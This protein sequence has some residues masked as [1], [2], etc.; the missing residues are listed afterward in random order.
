M[1]VRLAA[2]E[3]ETRWIFRF[4]NVR[5][6]RPSWSLDRDIR[7]MDLLRC[8]RRAL[9]TADDFERCVA[10]VSGQGCNCDMTI[11][12]QWEAEHHDVS[13]VD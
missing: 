11:M 6:Q 9:G 8:P 13:K 5:S 4:S 7:V 1:L 2:A 12:T 10:C 3:E